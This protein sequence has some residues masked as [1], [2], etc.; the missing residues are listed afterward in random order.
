MVMEYGVQVKHEYGVQV[1]QKLPILCKTN[2]GK[3]AIVTS[4]KRE[5]SWSTAA[6]SVPSFL[7]IAS[8]PVQKLVDIKK[9][10]P[11]SRHAN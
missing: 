8:K 4:R 9:I 1:K 10:N 7:Y 11:N 5:S 3:L 2:E 6:D